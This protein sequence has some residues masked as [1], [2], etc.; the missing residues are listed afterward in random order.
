MCACRI[1]LAVVYKVLWGVVLWGVVLWGVV[2]CG[3]VRHID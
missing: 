1:N 3:W 2:L